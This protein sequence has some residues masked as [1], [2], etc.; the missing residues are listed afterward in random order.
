MHANSYLLY[1]LCT[2]QGAYEEEEE[3]QES[4][5]QIGNT[6]IGNRNVNMHKG[7]VYTA[8]ESGEE[9]VWSGHDC[10]QRHHGTEGGVSFDPAVGG[11]RKFRP[12]AID[13]IPRTQHFGGDTDGL[14]RPGPEFGPASIGLAAN[15]SAGEFVPGVTACA[16]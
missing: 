15:T 6:D 4:W 14:A 5:T 2:T 7:V 13:F 11:V 10:E 1:M 3:E 12:D 16:S 9:L 8:L